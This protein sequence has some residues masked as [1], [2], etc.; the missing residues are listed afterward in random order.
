MTKKPIATLESMAS[1]QAV[2]QSV[3]YVVQEKE[4][5]L[6]LNFE[7]ASLG[8][9][10]NYLTERKNVDVIP[11]RDLE[12]IKVSL[13]SREPMTLSQAWETIYTLL[14]ANGFTIATVDGKHRVI[15]MQDHQQ[16][17]MP[18]YSSAKGVEPEHLEDSSKIIRY[19]YFCRN[20]KAGIAQSILS[21]L[22][23]ER[24]VQINAPLQACIITDKSQSIK[25]AMKIVTEI[26]KGGMRQNIRMKKLKHANAE[27]ITRLFNEHII[28][29]EGGQQDNRIR[30][31]S[32]EKKHDPAFFSKD[33]KILA[34]PMHNQLILMGTNDAI[35]RIVDFI[36]KYLDIPV[37]TA[38]SRLHVRELKYIAADKLKPMLERI[39]QP[40]KGQGSEKSATEGAYKFF[41]DVIIS[42]E[43]PSKDKD[44]GAQG[45][46]NR[47]IISCNE[48]DWKR[49]DQFITRLDQPAPQVAI[50]M[51]IV[52]ITN[53]G[54]RSL[55]TQIRPKSGVLGHE[56]NAG[57]F[58]LPGATYGI[59]PNGNNE[60]NLISDVRGTGDDLLSAHSTLISLGDASK[61]DVWALIRA[62]YSIDNTNIL[63]QPYLI[64]NNN[65]PAEETVTTSRKVP[66]ALEATG[67]AS[68]TRR[69]ETVE[70]SLKTVVTPRI[71]ATGV[72]DLEI[73]IDVGE[74]KTNS[75][76]SPDKT[77]RQI[78]TRV[79]MAA[80]EV[81]VLGGLTSSKH[82]NSRWEVPILS[83]L[84]LIGNLFRDRTKNNVRKNLYIF[85]RPTILKPH[86]G[87]GPDDYT[88]LKLDY[89]KYQVLGHD[90]YA[91]NSDPVQRYFFAPN[92]YG[93]KN[94]LS[95]LAEN[96][97][98]IIDA[99][100]ERKH[101]PN[102]VNLKN[103][104][105]YRG[106]IKEDASYGYEPEA[107]EISMPHLDPNKYIAPGLLE[108]TVPANIL[109]DIQ[110]ELD[111]MLA[112]THAESTEQTAPIALPDLSFMERRDN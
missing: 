77:N 97:M 73:K 10:L 14:E 56:M 95:D 102:E 108:E 72:M 101:I 54:T 38:K 44:G 23:G 43:T 27:N 37:G 34:E 47:L 31:I 81:L 15:S 3:T 112:P 103:D 2:D 19:I 46:G 85:I 61:D 92:R 16:N 98:P 111:R 68:L 45:F 7:D 22:L 78:I 62:A 55:G 5:E 106:Q 59:G 66:G 21:P 42:A 64:T 41:Q 30:I 79:S 6:F 71:N 84:P 100:T 91:T 74:F 40:P 90:D 107:M 104:P 67:N 49:L 88:Q 12:N 86:F 105:Y 36:D 48:E 93:I 51:M 80:G 57:A 29:P 94:K 28:Q 24:S 52:D 53:D 83:S 82:D 96:R 25:M 109:A 75:V 17:P 20:I 13:L 9:V 65:S 4:P 89:A 110:K 35:D 1:G 32:A 87:L 26:D 50:E 11:H 18:C 8:S 33:T 58:M 99:F 70:A 69:T 39:I 76:E 63:S 60:R